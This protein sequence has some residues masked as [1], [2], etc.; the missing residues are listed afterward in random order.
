MEPKKITEKRQVF[1]LN[2]ALTSINL[3]N[4]KSSSSQVLEQRACILSTS[5]LCPTQPG[6]CPVEVLAGTARGSITGSTGVV[7]PHLPSKSCHKREAREPLM[8]LSSDSDWV[9]TGLFGHQF[10]TE[11][12][13]NLHF[14]LS[15]PGFLFISL[16]PLFLPFLTFLL[17]I[18][19]FI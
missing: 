2:T 14:L 19:S 15:L 13:H 7:T 11:Q 4:C 3:N 17:P 9:Q 16:L 10:L 1:F 18:K 5:W 12:S 8:V 6:P